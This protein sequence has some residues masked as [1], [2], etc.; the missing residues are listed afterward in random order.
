MKTNCANMIELFNLDCM[1]VI[2]SQTFLDLTKDRKVVIVTDPPFNIN[3]KYNKY[4][5]NLPEDEYFDYLD[6]VL[7]MNRFPFVVIHYP[8]A[9]Y[10]LSFQVG[11]FPEKV[12]S[13][14]YNANTKNSIG[15]SPS[16][17]SCLISHWSSSH[18]RIRMTSESRS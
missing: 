12:V 11:M 13:W 10:K 9:L 17:A 7:T 14:V 4:K 5:D 1:E 16:S 2:G 6:E 3:Y 18:T 15:T 8:E